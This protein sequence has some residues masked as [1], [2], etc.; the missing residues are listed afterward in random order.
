MA[1]D[2]PGSGRAGLA[3]G[4]RDKVAYSAAFLAGVGYAVLLFPGAGFI[5]G[6][7]LEIAAFPL[8]IWARRRAK[9][10]GDGFGRL[11]TTLT[12]IAVVLW[13]VIAT[14]VLAVVVAFVLLFD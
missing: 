7:P 6:L 9:R 4:D 11:L 12:L 2:D 10:A 5:L 3:G 14:V 13:F 1:S 8:A